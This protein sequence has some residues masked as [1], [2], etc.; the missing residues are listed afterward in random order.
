MAPELIESSTGRKIRDSVDGA[1][2]DELRPTVRFARA[3]VL[4][5]AAQSGS[6][7]K[8]LAFNV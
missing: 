2:S 1:C 7:D 8:H 6:I 4:N 5:I 3:R